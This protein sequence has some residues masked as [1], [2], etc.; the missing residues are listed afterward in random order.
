MTVAEIDRK[1]TDLHWDMPSPIQFEALGLV[2]ILAARSQWDPECLAF[3]CM[4]LF[5]ATVVLGLKGAVAW[6]RAGRFRF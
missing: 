5:L 3:T 1:L 4:E 2:P 6:M